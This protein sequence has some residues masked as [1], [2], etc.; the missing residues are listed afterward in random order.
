MRKELQTYFN[1]K[2]GIEDFEYFTPA[3]K[4]ANGK[5]LGEKLEVDHH[6]LNLIQAYINYKGISEEDY[7]KLVKAGT[8]EEAMPTTPGFFGIG[9]KPLDRVE[10]SAKVQ[11]VK[12]EIADYKVDLSKY[13]GVVFVVFQKQSDIYKVLN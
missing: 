12:K 5:Q 10:I 13:T 11:A 4:G 1:D 9:K 8:I 2:F 7:D 6:R 3:F